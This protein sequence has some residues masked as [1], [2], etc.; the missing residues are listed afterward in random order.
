MS[1]RQPLVRRGT[2]DDLR[3]FVELGLRFY[4]ED[5]SRNAEPCQ[6]A[7]FAIAH[8]CDENRV[9]LAVGDPVA[10]CLFGMIAPHYLT[11]ELTAFKTAWYAVPGARGHG[12]HLLRAFEAWAKERGAHRIMVAGRQ[13]RTLSLLARL[14]YQSLETVYSKDISW[15]KQ[16]SQPS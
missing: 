2:M 11:G 10:A 13:D 6:L 5:G 7:R 16:P 3:R 1:D 9:A 15:Q 4:S 8:L 12:A 14:R